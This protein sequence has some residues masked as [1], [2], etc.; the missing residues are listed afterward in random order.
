MWGKGASPN[1]HQET[2]AMG[3]CSDSVS[4]YPEVDEGGDGEEESS[5]NDYDWQHQLRDNL[6]GLQQVMG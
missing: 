6:Q 4:G 3:N 1:G 2:N 5:S